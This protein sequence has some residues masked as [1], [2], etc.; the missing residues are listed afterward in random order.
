[1]DRE[2]EKN[3]ENDAIS[4]REKYEI[5]LYC[6]VLPRIILMSTKFKLE[7]TKHCVPDAFLWKN[8]LD[9]GSSSLS[10]PP[11]AG[12]KLNAPI[13]MGV[14]SVFDELLIMLSF[15][16]E[17]VNL[18]KDNPYWTWELNN[19][20]HFI[21]AVSHFSFATDLSKCSFAVKLRTLLMCSPLR[22]SD[23]AIS[24]E[25]LSNTCHRTKLSKTWIH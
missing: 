9:F 4:W 2:I 24:W 17:P 11:N 1:M 25:E 12:R 16:T 13:L 22:D 23:G 19:W 18:T 6:T 5:I 20:M 7:K 21:F 10:S 3:N 8:I 15:S 14:A